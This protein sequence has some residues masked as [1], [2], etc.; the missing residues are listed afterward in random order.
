MERRVFSWSLRVERWDIGRASW[1]RD[2]LPNRLPLDEQLWLC[3]V[4]STGFGFVSLRYVGRRGGFSAFCHNLHVCGRLF[5]NVVDFVHGKRL[6]QRDAWEDKG[7][8]RWV[9]Y[10]GWR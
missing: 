6:G 8:P 7:L 10:Q 4:E 2:D 5:P 1:I 3:A 9:V